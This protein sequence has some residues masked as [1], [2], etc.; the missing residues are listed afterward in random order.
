M[1]RSEFAANLAL[2]NR[3][4][5]AAWMTPAPLRARRPGLFARLLAL[6]A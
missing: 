4:P 1:N 5:R 6:F 3:T 2:A